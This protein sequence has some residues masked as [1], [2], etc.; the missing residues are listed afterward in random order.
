V[1]RKMMFKLRYDIIYV[2]NGTKIKYFT[3]VIKVRG[4]ETD[5]RT[6]VDLFVYKYFKEVEFEGNKSSI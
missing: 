4:H 6:S 3:Y 1:G 5:N 2:A